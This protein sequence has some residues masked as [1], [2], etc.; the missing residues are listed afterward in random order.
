MHL[1]FFASSTPLDISTIFRHLTKHLSMANDASAP[2]KSGL[3]LYANLLGSK[4]ST[5]GSSI[6]SA[7]VS[8]K[9]QPES[10]EDNEAAKKQQS[11]A[12]ND[13]S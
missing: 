9:Q 2:T 10:A 12:G 3:S 1:S 8:Y 6:T 13:N 7:P 5:P 11:L 4:S